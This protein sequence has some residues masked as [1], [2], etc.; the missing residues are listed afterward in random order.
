[1]TATDLIDR[2][3]AHKTLGAAPRGELAWLASHGSLRELD[4][5]DVLSAKGSRVEGLF[6]VLSGRIAI[7][8]DRGA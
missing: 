7:H 2:L 8:V 4:A 6:V 3:V 1:M 5:G